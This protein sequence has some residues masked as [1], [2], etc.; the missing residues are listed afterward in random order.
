MLQENPKHEIKRWSPEEILPTFSEMVEP[1]LQGGDLSD[2]QHETLS[3]QLKDEIIFF[4]K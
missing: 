4:L 3:S 1:L 2:K